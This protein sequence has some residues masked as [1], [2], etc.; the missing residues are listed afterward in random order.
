MTLHRCNK[1]RLFLDFD[2]GMLLQEKE[3]IQF[4]FDLREDRADVGDVG[5]AIE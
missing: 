4:C 1:V 5:G 3:E 2:G